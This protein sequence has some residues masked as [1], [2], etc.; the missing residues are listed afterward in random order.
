MY[1]FL[2]LPVPFI[3]VYKLVNIDEKKY[4]QSRKKIVQETQKLL[5]DLH[6]LGWHSVS[7]SINYTNKNQRMG[8]SK[9]Y[10]Q[11]ETNETL[12]KTFLDA[13][14]QYAQEVR[15]SLM[16]TA[17]RSMKVY[18]R[19]NIDSSLNFVNNC[20][21]M[22]SNEIDL[23]GLI[24]SDDNHIS[25]MTK[26]HDFDVLILESIQSIPFIRTKLKELVR[27]EI[28]IEVNM[29]EAMHDDAIFIQSFARLKVLARFADMRKNI[30]FSYGYSKVKD[31]IY[32]G[33]ESYQDLIKFFSPQ[34]LA[35]IPT[36]FGY[37][38]SIGLR[39]VSDRIEILLRDAYDRRH[40]KGVAE[41]VKIS[42]TSKTKKRSRESDG[43]EIKQTKRQKKEKSTT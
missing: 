17:A 24:L 36:L 11:N 4:L 39:C 28:P 34:D 25:L 35:T 37:H 7:L 42:K 33:R 6:E 14:N 23:V 40:V 3:R 29:G 8:P 13:F 9:E 26:T 16:N 27:R 12:L 19:V 2:N 20:S 32:E 21:K 41:I 22:I 10:K 38:Y 1:H 18:T 15:A 30:I 5:K 43:I 31:Y